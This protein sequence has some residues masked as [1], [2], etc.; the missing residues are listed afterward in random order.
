[1]KNLQLKKL[2]ASTVVAVA[3]VAAMAPTA[4]AVVGSANF[5]VTATLNSACTVG[6]IGALAFGAVTAFVAPASPTTTAL[7]SCT[8]TLAGVTAVFDTTGVITTSSA[9]AATPTGAGL[10]DNGLYYT[11]STAKGAV[12]AGAAATNAAIGSA[13]TFTY[14][15]TGAM[16]A[17]AGTCVG[18]SCTATAQVRTMTLNF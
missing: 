18:A 3:M 6:T 8:R 14:T 4:N 9:A 17:Q 5:N 11:L 7:I 16:A 10:L 2:A 13:D 12:T 15:I 1:M